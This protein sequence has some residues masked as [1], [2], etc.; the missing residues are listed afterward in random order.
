ML[1]TDSGYGRGATPS[2]IGENQESYCYHDCSRRDRP[3]GRGVEF[4]SGEDRE[5]GSKCPTFAV[6]GQ[7]WIRIRVK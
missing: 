2:S 6:A 3:S 1:R 5:G 4:G 7:L